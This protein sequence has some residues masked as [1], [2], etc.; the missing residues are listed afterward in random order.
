MPDPALTWRVEEANL[1]SFAA[2]K[3][4]VLHGWLRC[5]SEGGPRAR[6]IPS[7]H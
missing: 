2:L 6:T 1:D 7:V 5:F 3:R 4:A